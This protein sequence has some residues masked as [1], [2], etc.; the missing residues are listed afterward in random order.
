MFVLTRSLGLRRW[1]E[2]H[3]QHLKRSRHFCLSLLSPPLNSQFPSSR[4]VLMNLHDWPRVGRFTNQQSNVIE[5]RKDQHIHLEAFPC[6]FCVRLFELEGNSLD[7]WLLSW[8]TFPS[9]ETKLFLRSVWWLLCYHAN[10][11]TVTLT[12]LSISGQTQDSI[13]RRGHQMSICFSTVN[14][15][16]VHWQTK[17]EQRSKDPRSNQLV[18]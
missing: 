6:E 10:R 17:G 9:K 15:W 3:E 8:R 13:P 12:N 4:W 16:S 18:Q 1:Q 5:I 14:L 7:R 2:R 11:S